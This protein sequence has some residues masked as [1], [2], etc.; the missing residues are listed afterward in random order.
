MKQTTSQWRFSIP[1]KQTLL[2]VLVICYAGIV[3]AQNNYY[4]KG[5]TN[6]SFTNV[7]NWYTDTTGFAAN[8]ANAV[9]ATIA[10]TINDIVHFCFDAAD[11]PGINTD[12]NLSSGKCAGMFIN[13]TDN[14]LFSGNFELS[15][16]LFSNGNGAF[17]AGAYTITYSG[18]GAQTLNFGAVPQVVLGTIGVTNSNYTLTGNLNTGFTN[19]SIINSSLTLNNNL[20]CGKIT[21]EDSPS[22]MPRTIN[23]SN[24]TLDLLGIVNG[25]TV[26]QFNADP[27]TITYDFENTVFNLN[28]ASA[29]IIGITANGMVLTDIASINFNNGNNL[30][31]IRTTNSISYQIRTRDFRINTPIV[32]SL[33]SAGVPLRS[34]ITAQNL[35]FD[36]P[37][38]FDQTTLIHFDVENIINNS[39]CNL[40]AIIRS[41]TGLLELDAT[42]G[43]IITDNIAYQGVDFLGDGFQTANTYDLG[44]NTG[45]VAWTAPVTTRIFYWRG[46]NGNWDDGTHWAI[47]NP[48]GTPAAT[49]PGLCIP[50]LSDD[51]IVDGLSGAPTITN[52]SIANCQNITFSGIGSLVGGIGVI[53]INGS[54]DFTQASAVNNTIYFVGSGVSSLTSGAF[55]YQQIIYF[56]GPGNYTIVN[57]FNSLN[58]INHNA[59]T[60]NIIGRNLNVNSFISFSQPT[61]GNVRTLDITDSRLVLNRSTQ[62]ITTGAAWFLNINNLSSFTSTGSTIETTGLES[63]VST[64]SVSTIANPQ[65]D[66]IYNNIIFSNGAGS[67]HYYSACGN[68][69]L[70]TNVR[71]N[72]VTFNSNGE[73]SKGDDGSGGHFVNDYFFQSGKKYLFFQDNNTTYDILNAIHTTANP[74]GDLVQIGSRLTGSRARL[75]HTGIFTVEGAMIRDINSV[76]SVLTINNG[77]DLGNNLNVV[78]GSPAV[79]R[80]MFWRPGPTAGSGEWNDGAHWAIITSGYPAALADPE[81]DPSFSNTNLCIPRPIDNVYFDNLSFLASGET[82]N[83]DF[84]DA[85]CNNMLWDTDAA[86]WLPNFTAANVTNSM[87]N[88][89]GRMEFSNGINANNFN[90][91]VFMRGNNPGANSQSI[92]SNGVTFNNAGISFVGGG[93]YDILD[94]LTFRRNG[95]AIGNGS[96]GSFHFVAGQLFTHGNILNTGRTEVLVTGL[97]TVDISNS[98]LNILE[99][100]V[101]HHDDPVKFSAA[102]SLFNM[103]SASSLAGMEIVSS[104]AQPIIYADAIFSAPNH[105]FVEVSPRSQIRNVSFETIQF[106]TPISTLTGNISVGTLIYRDTSINYLAPRTSGGINYTYTIR[107]SLRAIGQPCKPIELKSNVVGLRANVLS[108]GC[109]NLNIIDGFIQDL[110]GLAPCVA[111]NY[112]VFGTGVNTLNW[113]IMDP[114]AATLPTNI[115][116]SCETF[117]IDIEAVGFSPNYS[118]SWS[119][120]ETTS[121]ISVDSAGVFDVNIFFN[122]DCAIE[123]SIVVESYDIIAPDI[124][125]NTVDTLYA[126]VGECFAVVPATGYDAL[127]TDNCILDSTWVVFSG[128]TS[129]SSSKIPTAPDTYS[130]AGDTLNIGT[131]TVTW[132]TNDMGLPANEST[133]THTIVVLDTILP[134]FTTPCPANN[135]TYSNDP[136][137]CGALVSWTPPAGTDNCS[138]ILTSTH[139]PAYFF[140]VGDTTTI[141]YT[142]TDPSG[143]ETTCSFDIAVVDDE[144]PT[145]T[146]PVDL[147]NVPASAGLCEATGVILGVPSITDNC[148]VTASAVN[149]APSVFPAGTTVVTW[150]ITDDSGNT[151]TCVQN[152]TVID[153]QNPTIICPAN[154]TNI[155]ADIDECTAVI[156]L[157]TPITADNCGVAS[158]T[159]N[160]P[161]SF[162]VGTTVV[163]WTVTDNSGRTATCPQNVTVIDTQNPT[164]TCPVDLPNVSNDLGL[165]EASGIVL[166]TPTTG[167]NC[168]VASVTNNAPSVFPIGETI[169]SWT[170]TDNSGNTATCPQSITVVDNEDPTI[171]CP[172]NLPNV[173]SDAGS[174][175]ATGV[176]LG[177]PVLNDNC[178]S[179]AN[180]IASTVNDAPGVFSAGT[181]L[182]TWTIIDDAGNSVTCQQSITVIDS[183]N[184]T[185]I[186]PADILNVSNDLGLCEASGIDLGTP[187]TGDNCGVASIGSNAPS[188]FPVGAT[189]VIWT[190]TDNSGRTATCP[191]NVEVIDD[192]DPTIT[193]PVDLTSVSND[194]GLCEASGV[195]LGIPT[196]GDNC[197]VASV[198]NDTPLVFP[199]GTTLVTW[200]I[201]DNSGNKATCPQNITVVDDENPTITCPADL[202]N[203]SADAGSCDA[204]G[205]VLGTA[206]IIDNCPISASVTNDAPSAFLVGTT[207][208]TWEIT[209][210][211]G[212]TSTCLQNVTVI[213]NQNPVIVCPTVTDSIVMD[214][215]A[216]TYSHA[217]NAWDATSSDNCNIDTLYFELTG[218]TTGNG[219]TLNG[220]VFNPGLTTITWTTEDNS[221]NIS[222]CQYT[223]VV[224]DDETPVVTVCPSDITVNTEPSLCSFTVT[225]AS[226]D[227][228]ATDNCTTL[229]YNYELSGATTGTG[230][231]TL[232]GVTFNQG[233]TTVIWTVRDTEGNEVTCNFTVTVEDNEDPIIS[234]CPSDVLVSTDLAQCTYTHSG[235]SWNPTASDNCSVLLDPVYTLSGATVA[236]GSISLHG[237]A[238]EVGVTTVTWTIMDSDGN[239][240]ECIFDVTVEDAQAPDFSNCPANM[241]VN[242]TGINGCQEEVHWTPPTASDN[243]IGFTVVSTHNPGDLFNT[244]TTTVVYTVTDASGN[245]D[246]C[247]FDVTIYDALAPVFDNCP[248]N[249]SLTNSPGQC[250]AVATWSTITATDNCDTPVI[251][252][253]HTSGDFFPVGITV[254]EYTAVDNNG[255][256]VTCQFTIEVSDT[257]APVI[258][259]MPAD[260]LYGCVGESVFWTQPIATDNCLI[261]S[262]NSGTN[263]S[264]NVFPL[265]TTTVTYTAVDN[266]GNSISETFVVVVNPLPVVSITSEDN[267]M[268]VCTG[269]SLELK[270]D[271]VVSGLTYEWYGDGANL[272]G[273][274]PI[275]T[276]QG[277]TTSTGDSYSVL[278]I[279]Q[280]GCV[281]SAKIDI[282]VKPCGIKITEAVTPNGDGYNDFFEIE[283]L[284][285]YPNT[286]VKF[287]NRWGLELYSSDD[288]KNDWDGRSRN[289]LDAGS[290]LLPE[291]TYYYLIVLGGNES[292]P[293]FGEIYKGFFFIKR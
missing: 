277:E 78:I 140:T 111:T 219:I 21:I 232:N 202:S 136:G 123:R 95:G 159:N 257:E 176:A 40:D 224:F 102:N 203:V 94:N 151:E 144:D 107:D 24:R 65:T 71:A 291:G 84:I 25:L 100:Y 52:T 196:T 262:F 247:Q 246:V 213:D 150:T 20:I 210:D 181:T 116:A 286:K 41:S 211:A 205:I 86:T 212:N 11:I 234:S 141:T 67:G 179:I 148:S 254:V 5:T 18:I 38:T 231:A 255:N 80:E 200:T 51:V 35:I 3:N 113:T 132:H 23:F 272:V 249:I 76:A 90:G 195:V 139:S 180:L 229:T 77:V 2:F 9:P 44:F 131:T 37:H 19:F 223:V 266:A 165:C 125:C 280:Y 103:Q 191:Q 258:A 55:T 17:K 97:N 260:T 184:P 169:I 207:I 292:S 143:N 236:T 198:T 167:D 208:V 106:Q 63:V 145:I 187:T 129:R 74:C 59:G 273:N 171:T 137:D 138:A 204:T 267:V 172:A 168:A 10:P 146:C 47:N 163:T 275:Y 160:A 265:G 73:I 193:C 186:C 201:E 241:T 27:S 30:T 250:G 182:V 15:G 164:I 289:A 120:G 170:V 206:S 227:V 153:N 216:C 248:A 33:S 64:Y 85:Y 1:F 157:A 189:V 82:V 42:A 45:N 251:T 243:C 54:A 256:T 239:S 118:Y 26:L 278:A 124:T 197:G 119:T 183:E 7:G 122:A 101:G 287:F 72:S 142:L 252:S 245:Q 48:L 175:D 293:E 240:I 156:V 177:N 112:N 31:G 62:N 43:L 12:I 79:S 128:V 115:L 242:L 244:G 166:G 215:A 279:D 91:T 276:V 81:N 88:V 134:V 269:E 89:F 96:R 93:R 130:L 226:M 178:T 188:A 69:A 8:P 87:L 228:D 135:Y 271:P 149:D 283:N 288:Y 14:Y 162:P 109:D 261:A 192:E 34:T 108:L 29:N 199:V 237:Q 32:S 66:I 285:F 68:L 263:M 268:A 147:P 22:G 152:V 16:S 194:A 221:G 126:G 222:S 185:I 57:D 218:A 174:C 36:G 6:N 49:N 114:S 217:G 83:I 50:T 70:P 225:D 230:T 154:L 121:S 46:G 133:C 290:D 190:V 56:S 259:N 105:K 58:H 282:V 173:P 161:F 110:V 117:P 158:V 4:W 274:G 92:I 253:S 155:P 99:N 214:A 39:G 61:N 13:S 98:T 60:L 104:S 75:R 28:A 264:G 233:V 220:V 53:N 238:F 209:D 270:V 127:I 284:E 281:S 235:N